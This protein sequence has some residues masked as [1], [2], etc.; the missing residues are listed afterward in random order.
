MKIL[1]KST[2]LFWCSFFFLNSPA[3]AEES[4]P[5]VKNSAQ[6][7]Q[8][9]DI[10]E[11]AKSHSYKGGLE[12]GE[13]RVQAQLAKPQRKISPVVDRKETDEKE[14]QEHD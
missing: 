10:I 9:T 2:L 5:E 7:I 13:L 1:F 14:P 11:K 4:P 8:D 12:E 3:F 6:L